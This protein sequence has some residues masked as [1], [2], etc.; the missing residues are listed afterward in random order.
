MK[1]PKAIIEAAF[2]VAISEGGGKSEFT[3]RDFIEVLPLAE[4]A[5]EMLEA[6]RL[7]LCF[8]ENTTMGRPTINPMASISQ[9]IAKA[10]AREA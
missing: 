7:A 2:D 3:E 8:C 6:L 1:D 10:T 9:A 5:P 4:A